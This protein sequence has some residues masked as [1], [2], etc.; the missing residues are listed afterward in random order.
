[1]N[2]VKASVVSALAILCTTA[3]V[4]QQSPIY[5]VTVTE[6]TVKAV[7][8]QYRSGPTKID[9]RGTV[10]LPDAKGEAVVES[11]AGSTE[12]DVKLDRVAAPTR[13]GSGYLT[14]VLW[15]ITPE[16]HAKNLGEVLPDAD[17][18][19]RLHATTDLQA[20]GMIVTAEPYSAVRQ[21]SDVVVMENEIRPDTVGKIQLIQAKYELL[22]RGHY[23]YVKPADLTPKGRKVSMAEYEELV[24]LYQAQNAVQIA[25]SQLADRYAEETFT[26]A[27]DLL[28]QAQEMQ[29]RKADRSTVISTARQAAQTAEDARAIATTRRRDAELAAAQQTA[30]EAQANAAA[31][32]R[33]AEQARIEASADRARV[34]EDREARAVETAPQPPT[35]V[36]ATAAPESPAAIERHLDHNQD[37]SGQ[38]E[39]RISLLRQLNAI[40][41]ATDT[42]RGLVVTLADAAFTNAELNQQTAALIA[43]A[44]RAVAAHPGLTVQVEGH[45]DT[46]GSGAEDISRHRAEAVRA[47]LLGGGLAPGAVTAHGLG[48]RRPAYSNATA[49]GR[50]QNRRVEITISGESIGTLPYWDRTYP[51]K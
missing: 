50:M 23:T 38:K 43:Q 40:L 42:P 3:A 39:L 2:S 1:M 34:T 36:P 51:L 15:A 27:Q 13:F 29:A 19:A 20:F 30:K 14:Y 9:F 25:Q 24:E 10:L 22:P 45:M 49:S 5:Q 16:G 35:T 47:A 21:P 48:T 33:S 6:R 37:Q 8:Y 41:P 46:P 18:H 32:Q 7:N 31:A 17:D 12:V 44:A 4:A 11:K 26:K 28:R